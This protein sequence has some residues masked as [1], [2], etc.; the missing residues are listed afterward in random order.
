MSK[1]DESMEIKVYNDGLPVFNGTLGEF[2]RSNNYDLDVV[3]W[4]Q[5]LMEKREVRFNLMHSGQ[6]QIFKISPIESWMDKYGI[7]LDWEAKNALR[8]A[9]WAEKNET[10]DESIKAILKVR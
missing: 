5:P 7:N 3:N 8:Q 1:L 2:F 10:R 9:I 6:W 4:C